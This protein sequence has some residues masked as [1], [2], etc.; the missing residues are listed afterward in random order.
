[1]KKQ[2]CFNVKVCIVTIVLLFIITGCNKTAKV[3]DTSYFISTSAKYGYN[4]TDVS[5]DPSI[6]LEALFGYKVL[7]YYMLNS[8][9]ISIGFIR[10]DNLENA[11]GIYTDIKNDRKQTFESEGSQGVE[12]NN[13]L[14]N[15]YV[16]DTDDCYLSIIRKE[17]MVFF[18][19]AMPSETTNAKKMINEIDI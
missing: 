19:V 4:L 8:E 6:D 10:S 12:S 13:D 2:I 3:I 1:M 9:D 18:V 7:E 5:S 11:E 16:L 15:K 17:K 14:S